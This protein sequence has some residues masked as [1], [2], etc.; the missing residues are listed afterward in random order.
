ME[1]HQLEHGA[2]LPADDLEREVAALYV[3]HSGELLRFAAFILRP[4]DGAGDAVQETFLRYFAERKCGGSIDNPRA[5]LY[6]VLHNYIRDRQDRASV[7]RE[8]S[9]EGTSEPLDTAKD[10]EERLV[11][12]QIA[13]EVVASLTSRELDCLL[14]R[15]E[16]MSY[17]QMAGTLGIRSG[18]VGALLTRVHKK[19]GLAAGNSRS[20]RMEIADALGSLLEGGGTYSS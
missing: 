10:P 1:R 7:K 5:W 11:R 13:R 9:S 14:L 15:A 12:S 3:R 19:L 18:T 8:V 17:E 6:R 16:G 4:Q 20:V 2:A